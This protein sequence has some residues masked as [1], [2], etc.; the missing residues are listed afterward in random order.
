MHVHEQ[1]QPDRNRRRHRGHHHDLR[2]RIDDDAE[3]VLSSFDVAEGPRQEGRPDVHASGFEH[4]EHRRR[5]VTV[6]FAASG[7]ST[8]V[9]EGETLLDAAEE[10][11]VDIPFDCR[12]GICGQCKTKLVSGRVVMVVQDAQTADDRRRRL[13]L[14]CQA[15]P[16][17]DVVVEA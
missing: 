8:S 5:D 3:G 12:A 2:H 17:R 7:I 9:E 11:G 15:R 4:P 13:V 14:A 10:L 6:Q 16:V 1:H